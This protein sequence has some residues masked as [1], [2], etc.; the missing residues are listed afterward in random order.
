MKHSK[1]K[2]ANILTNNN[3]ISG[4]TNKA[5]NIDNSLLLEPP[6]PMCWPVGS[7]PSKDQYIKFVIDWYSYNVDMLDIYEILFP[8]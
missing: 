5:N 6:F 2:S 8:K 3:H 1:N 4:F 7:Y